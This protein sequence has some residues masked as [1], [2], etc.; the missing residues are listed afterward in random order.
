VATTEVEEDVDGGPLGVLSLSPT[1]ATTEVK[2]NVDGGP[3]TGCCQRVRQRPPPNLKKTSMAGPLGVLP[4]GSAMATTK[5]EE[6]IDGRT[7]GVATGRSGSGHHRNC[8]R[9]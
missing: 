2:E 3:P 4:A 7:P 6:D 1:V 9:R 5:V 8:K